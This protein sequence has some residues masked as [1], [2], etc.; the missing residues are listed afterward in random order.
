M[1]KLKHVAYTIQLRSYSVSFHLL[2]IVFIAI[3]LKF[4]YSKFTFI[5][6]TIACKTMNRFSTTASSK[7]KKA[8]QHHA[9]AAIDISAISQLRAS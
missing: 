3:F 4:C 1:H 2:I 9:Q 6:I 7:P 8:F 5:P